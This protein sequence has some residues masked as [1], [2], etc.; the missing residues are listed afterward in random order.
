V[1]RIAS[2]LGWLGLLP[3]LAG[4][5]FE[6]VGGPGWTEAALRAYAAAILAFMGGI[7]WG[8]AIADAKAPLSFES[9]LQLTLSV[10][11]ALVAWFALMRPLEAGLL[12][13]AFAFLIVLVGDMLA[14][15]A[16]EAP[17]W[18]PRLRIPLTVAVI[19]S[20]LIATWA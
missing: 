1:P 19:L 17:A 7:H 3:F 5:L 6:I 11:P 8:L 18:Y 15:L 14:T 13:M 9:K 10:V 4:A 20:L 12:I 2:I 16:G